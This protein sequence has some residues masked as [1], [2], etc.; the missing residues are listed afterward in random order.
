VIQAIKSSYYYWKYNLVAKAAFITKDN[1]ND[2][3]ATEKFERDVTL[4]HIDIDG[5]DY[6]IW[7]ALHCVDPII[8]VVEYNSLF[9]I[10]RPIAIPYDERFDRMKAHYSGLYWG[11]SLASFYELA[12]E[13]KY[14]FIGCNSAGNNAYFLRNDKLNDKVKPVELKKGFVESKY[15]ESRNKAGQL[16][17]LSKEEQRLLIKG[18]RVYNTVTKQMEIL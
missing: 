1:I 13:R 18:M 3:I 8:V 4:L 6:Y 10:E 12:K 7:E 11:A 5:N 14:S 16:T 17:Y 2:L 15:R 9:G